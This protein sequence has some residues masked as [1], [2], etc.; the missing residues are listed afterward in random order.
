MYRFYLT[1]ILNLFRVPYLIPKLIYMSHH[2]EKYTLEYRYRLVRK[3]VRF[4]KRTAN[5]WTKAFGKENLPKE[6]G[7]IMFANHQGKYDALGIVHTHDTPCS[8]VMDEKRSR[9]LVASQVLDLLEGKRLKKDDVRQAMRIILEMAEESAAGKRFL[10]FP[11]GGYYHNR[12]KVMEF[13]PGSFKSAMKAKVPIVPVAL[14][15]SYKAFEGFRIGSIH[16]QVHYLEPIPYE[17]YKDMKT[18]EVAEMVRQRIVDKIE[19]V[20]EARKKR[21]WKRWLPF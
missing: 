9:G 20:L 11:E 19:E 7:Y 5:I 13:K 2:I 1:I 10:I 18:I 12:N 3:I 8:I 4:I 6:G 15:D 16:T 21:F 17:E 14:V